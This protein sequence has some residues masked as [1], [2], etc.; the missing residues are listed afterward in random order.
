MVLLVRLALTLVLVYAL[1]WIASHL[2]DAGVG[3]VELLIILVLAV[4]MAWPAGARLAR[5]G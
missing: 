4:L 3:A 5:R 1:A 2:A